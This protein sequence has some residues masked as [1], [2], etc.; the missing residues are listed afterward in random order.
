M[1]SPMAAESRTGGRGPSGRGA[2]PARRTGC[3]TTRR[4]VSPRSRAHLQ[5]RDPAQGVLVVDL[6][7]HPVGEAQAVDAPAAVPPAPD[8]V[9]VVEV[10]VAGLQEA[11]VA[12]VRL[13]ARP[14]CPCRTECGPG[15]GRRSRGPC[16]AGGPA[17]RCGRRSRSP[18]WDARPG[19]GP[20]G[21]VLR[22]VGHVRQLEAWSAGGRR[23]CGCAAPAAPACRSASPGSSSRGTPAASGSARCARRWAGRRRS[24]RRRG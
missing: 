5:P 18:R 22:D 20:R 12:A 17:R 6:L 23:S 11:E 3:G 10:L 4:A 2:S 8:V 21:Q 19:S 15:S 9:G 1:S 7:Q 13:R 24:G 16:R 14:A